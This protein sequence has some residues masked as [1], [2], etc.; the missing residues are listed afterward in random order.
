LV[1]VGKLKDKELD[2]LDEN[3]L[4]K[5]LGK[6]VGDGVKQTKL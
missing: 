5:L 3:E 2:M 6:P 1:A 4:G